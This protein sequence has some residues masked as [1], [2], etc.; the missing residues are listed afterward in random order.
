M[1]LKTNL[2]IAVLTFAGCFLLLALRP[3]PASALQNVKSVTGKVV[4]VSEDANTGKVLVNL[5]N[6]EH[7]YVIRR[8][9]KKDFDFEKFRNNLL[10]RKATLDF[11]GYRNEINGAD[12]TIPI[13]R[14]TVAGQTFWQQPMAKFVAN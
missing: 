9:T 5:S 2:F 13:S 6:D 11:V 12:Q 3:V 1:P 8:E 7:I 10:Y 14:V 4:R